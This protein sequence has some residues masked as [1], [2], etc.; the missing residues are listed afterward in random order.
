MLKVNVA[1][2]QKLCTV[3]TS[4]I[5]DFS[6]VV[7]INSKKNM[8]TISTLHTF[9]VLSISIVTRANVKNQYG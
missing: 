7:Y 5:N 8:V 1:E 2:P 6:P 3:I 9:I 4:R